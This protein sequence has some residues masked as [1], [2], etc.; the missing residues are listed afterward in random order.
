MKCID[1][2]LTWMIPFLMW[3]ATGRLVV[4][5]YLYGNF[6]QNPPMENLEPTAVTGPVTDAE[7][8][9]AIDLLKTTQ[10][11]LRQSLEGLTV[12]QLV[13]KPSPDRW[14]VA[15]CVEHI[16]L[17][18]KGIFRA[19]QAGLRAPADPDRRSAIK[20]SDVFVIKAGRSR[21]SNLPAPDPFL[22]TGRW[23]DAQTA[24]A[25]FDEQR[26]AA[27]DFVLAVQEDL[28]T[29]YF[30]HYVMG[31]LDAYQAVLLMAAHAERH[32]KQIQEVKTSPGFPQ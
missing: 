8:A 7:R 25:A 30:E 3:A 6:S 23:G 18:E 26:K 20:V 21:S 19:V 22:P 1:R 11:H 5:A 24:L 4:W 28:R 12:E 16:A 15:D 29:H 10:D 14:S 17:V 32:R 27:I 31:T 13:Y 2:W 9:Y